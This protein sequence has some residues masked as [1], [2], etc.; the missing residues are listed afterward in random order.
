M[1]TAEEMKLIKPNMSWYK[2]TAVEFCRS[3]I[4]VDMFLFPLQYIDASALKE[5]VENTAGTL[6]TYPMFDAATDGPRFE[7]DLH[8][9]LTQNTA[10]EAVMRI[11]CTRGMKISNF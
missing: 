3:Q 2:D 7:S 1:G 9:T 4:C 6:N 8:K 10:F 11:R 5:L